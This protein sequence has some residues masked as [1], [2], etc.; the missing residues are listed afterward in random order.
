MSQS[1]QRTSAPRPT[2]QENPPTSQ[3]PTQ[4]NQTASQQ[5]GSR[6]VQKDVDSLKIPQSARSSSNGISLEHWKWIMMR[7]GGPWRVGDTPNAA[8]GVHVRL[9]RKLRVRLEMIN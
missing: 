6:N 3:A 8:V 5:R 7:T 2:T 1:P 9:D 4:G